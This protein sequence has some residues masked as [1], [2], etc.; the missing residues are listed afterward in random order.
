MRPVEAVPALFILLLAAGV[1]FGTG[2]LSYWDGPTP[3]AR[4]FPAILA[5]AGTA[6]ALLLLWAQWRGI[7]TVEVQF[8]SPLGLFRVGASIA[9]LVGF[10]AGIP[11]IG[12]VPMLGAFVLVMLLGVLRQPVVPSVGT[13]AFVA[14]FVHFV[15]VR[16]LSV[17][18]PMPLG[19]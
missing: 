13:A 1:Y 3:G 18:L 2:G 4:F 9:A 15:F 14:G 5:V 12:F 17:P 10:A 19:I 7:E 16:W 8:L 11:V 6:V